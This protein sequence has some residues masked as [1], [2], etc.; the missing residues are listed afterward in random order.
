MP[1]MPGP[2]RA[3]PDR[4]IIYKQSTCKVV[5]WSQKSGDSRGHDFGHLSAK[6]G[7]WTV[8]PAQKMV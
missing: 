3:H 4:A 5:A 6:L 8:A 1:T 2:G 7:P